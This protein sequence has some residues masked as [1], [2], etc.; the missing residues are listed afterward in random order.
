[1]AACPTTRDLRIMSWHRVWG[2]L[3]VCWWQ[4]QLPWGQ[5]W[6]SWQG[7]HHHH[8]DFSSLCSQRALGDEG[9]GRKSPSFS[10]PGLAAVARNRGTFLSWSLDFRFCLIRQKLRSCHLGQGQGN[11]ELSPNP[12]VAVSSPRKGT[13]GILD[14]GKNNQR[15]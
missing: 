11:T 3:A 15:G 9:G 7:H 1:M 6:R 12:T 5:S 14:L 2:C 8:G 4:Q 13:I 10:V